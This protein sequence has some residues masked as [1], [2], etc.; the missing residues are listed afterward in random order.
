[1]NRLDLQKIA[2][3]RLQESRALLAAGYPDGAYY[4]AGYAVECALKACVAKRTQQHDFPD[5]KLVN[6]SHTHDLGKLFQ[7]AELKIELED[8]IKADPSIQAKLDTIQDWSEASR[9]ES[10]NQQDAT[11]LLE[12]IEDR[13]GGLLPWIKLRW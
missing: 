5:K 10:K 11:D 12:A 6:D 1:M 13:T 4:L 3:I 7:L 9:Y 2:E 8:A